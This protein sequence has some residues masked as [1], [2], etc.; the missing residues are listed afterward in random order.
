M[1]YLKKMLKELQNQSK[2]KKGNTSKSHK[3][4]EHNSSLKNF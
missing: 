1:K 4:L 2:K 3:K